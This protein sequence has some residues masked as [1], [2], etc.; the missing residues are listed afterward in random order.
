[1]PSAGFLR[2]KWSKHH[3]FVVEECEALPVVARLV[4]LPPSERVPNIRWQPPF[5]PDLTLISRWGGPC[6]R[7]WWVCHICH[8]RVENLY[9]PP[10]AEAMDWRCRK[11]HDLIY[12]SQRYGFA[13]PLG[14]ILTNRKRSTT[15]KKAR[16]M[17]RRWDRLYEERLKP[18]T[19]PTPVVSQSDRK[20]TEKFSQRFKEQ[21]QSGNQLVIEATLGAPKPAIPKV[22]WEPRAGSIVDSEEERAKTLARLRQFAESGPTSKIRKQALRLLKQHARDLKRVARIEAKNQQPKVVSQKVCPA[23]KLT[24]AQIAAAEAIASA[25]EDATF[26]QV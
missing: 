17:A 14:K 12:G 9:R 2:H 20:L 3:R 7:W 15:I 5:H 24:P 22:F 23:F 10:S 1:M 4:D 25:L 26:D 19:Q 6:L 13:H 16:R 8:R 11:C 21:T 18:M